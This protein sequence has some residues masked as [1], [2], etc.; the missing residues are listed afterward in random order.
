[1]ATSVQ[2]SLAEYLGTN[3]R[4]D[5]EYIDGEVLERNMGQYEHARVQAALAAW[6]WGKERDWQIQVV[7]EWRTQVSET[8]VRIPDLVIV[9]PGPQAKVLAEPPVLVIEILS[10]D[11]SY[12]ETKRRATDYIEMGAHTVWIIDPETRSG[13]WCVGNVWT[14]TRTLDVPGTAIYVNLDE[15]FEQALPSY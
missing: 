10:P 7:T 4:P 5:R 12:S 9:K 13:Q 3:Y 2:I 8:R 15:L 1:M 14:S 11:D 6:F